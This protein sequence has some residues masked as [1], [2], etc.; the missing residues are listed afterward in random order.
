MKPP[1]CPR[2]GGVAKL[3][4][5]DFPS[6]RWPFTIL[7]LPMKMAGGPDPSRPLYVCQGCGHNWDKP[8]ALS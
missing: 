6:S 7:P 8:P 1:R 4:P 3:Y 2:C 5:D